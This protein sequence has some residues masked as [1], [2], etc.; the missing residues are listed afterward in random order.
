MIMAIYNTKKAAEIKGVSERRIR[1]MIQ[2]E[3]IKAE[4]I[5]R[6]WII[7]ETELEKVKVYKQ[8]GRPSKDKR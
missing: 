7:E 3:I 6:D 5:G 4:K 2:D 8:S 1:Q